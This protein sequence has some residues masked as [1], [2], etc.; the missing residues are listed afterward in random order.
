M[1]TVLHSN[2]LQLRRMSGG[3]RQLTVHPRRLPVNTV[4]HTMSAGLEPTTFQLLFH[5][6]TSSAT[7]LPHTCLFLLQWRKYHNCG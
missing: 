6:A 4:I 3:R 5:R 1:L 2:F 7:D